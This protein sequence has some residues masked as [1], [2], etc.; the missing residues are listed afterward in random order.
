M[1][2]AGAA[3]D[4]SGPVGA[5]G[6]SAAAK[7]KTSSIVLQQRSG[8]RDW[9]RRVVL[10]LFFFSCCFCFRCSARSLA[11]ALPHVAL[12]NH[13]ALLS[14]T[15]KLLA[16]ASL[17]GILVRIHAL[18]ELHRSTRSPSRSAPQPAS[19]RLCSPPRPVVGDVDALVP[20]W[21]KAAR[22]SAVKPFTRSWPSRCGNPQPR[23]SARRSNA[24]QR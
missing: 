1:L 9:L 19:R 16:L 11:P 20:C 22:W 5:T 2:G 15:P 6:S 13:V 23:T 8:L 24:S 3:V 21:A 17:Q 14:N 4:G 10:D 18:G 7:E 12:A